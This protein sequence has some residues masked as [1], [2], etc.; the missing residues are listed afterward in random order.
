MATETRERDFPFTLTRST[1]S[2]D[3][4]L[5]FEGYAAV[6]GQ[7]AQVFDR[8]GEYDEVI[9][10]GAFKQT[11]NRGKP[12]L[13]FNHG[14]HPLIGQMPLGTITELREDDRGL[15]V[16]ARL[17][18]N[19]LIAPVRDAI[20]DG[21][22]TGMSFRFEAVKETWSGRP[23]SKCRMGELRT[24]KEAR[25]PELGPVVLATYSETTAAVRSAFRD[26][27][28][29]VEG[30]TVNIEARDVETVSTQELTV[31]Q[32]VKE[33]VKARWGLDT[34]VDV[35]TTDFHE[36][37]NRLVFTVSGRQASEYSG[38]WQ[39]N[40]S[41]ADGVVT[42]SGDPFAVQAT[43]Y[44]PRS[45]DPVE[46][47]PTETVDTDLGSSTEVAARSS[48]EAAAPI[49]PRGPMTNQ[50]DRDAFLREV[51]LKRRGIKIGAT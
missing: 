32:L 50:S 9:A 31:E 17:T 25:V 2:E 6:F 35:D 37:D 22:I 49:G 16:R 19:W 20:A 46:T 27:E 38:L 8:Q 33:A 29:A 48:D 47:S 40:Y 42:L 11:I 44:E 5:N 4:G 15:F 3:D 45:L 30:I 18:D 26:L 51:E 41:Y 43:S 23:S 12:I 1:D 13:M 21:A 39:A 36:A 28:T 34:L 7:R 14:K 10:P 24:V